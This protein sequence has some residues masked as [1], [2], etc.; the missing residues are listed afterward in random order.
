[1]KF[2]FNES[3]EQA[4]ARNIEDALREDIGTGDWTAMLVPAGRSTRAQVVVRE[5]AVLCGRD[6][7]DGVFAALDRDARIEWR[8]DEGAAMPSGSTVCARSPAASALGR[9]ANRRR[10]SPPCSRYTTAP[11]NETV[12]TAYEIIITLT[13]IVSSG[14]FCSAGTSGTMSDGKSDAITSMPATIGIATTPTRRC[15]LVVSKA[16]YAAAIP[17]PNAVVNSYRFANGA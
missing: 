7:F 12:R 14:P 10:P 5:D 11:Q 3:L 17:K 16:R 8:F 13:W 6:W 4:R 15:R 9:E 1:M 2:E